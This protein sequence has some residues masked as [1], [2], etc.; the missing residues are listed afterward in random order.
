[1]RCF[2]N[3][4]NWI[5]AYWGIKGSNLIDTNISLA[6]ASSK[7]LS[8]RWA[9]KRTVHQINCYFNVALFHWAFAK[10]FKSCD[11]QKASLI[12]P[13]TELNSWLYR[14]RL[15]LSSYTGVRPTYFCKVCFL[16]HIVYRP[17][18]WRSSGVDWPM[19]TP[20]FT[21]YSCCSMA[22]LLSFFLPVGGQ[23]E[24]HFKNSPGGACKTRRGVNDTQW[25]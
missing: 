6:Q 19:F 16:A 13:D 15:S 11:V 4:R 1:M 17:A 18:W 10:H 24:S 9:K 5:S 25:P 12:T 2:V 7:C 23:R 3:F 20:S 21:C 8:T 14:Q 22:H